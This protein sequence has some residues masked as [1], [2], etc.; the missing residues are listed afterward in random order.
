MKAEGY[1]IYNG[2]HSFLICVKTNDENKTLL[3]ICPSFS[4]P[5]CLAQVYFNMESLPSNVDLPN[6]NI[7]KQVRSRLRISI[8]RGSNCQRTPNKFTGLVDSTLHTYIC[9]SKQARI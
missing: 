7:A 1:I 9:Q 3:V 5:G 6:D 4:F 8:L 2:F